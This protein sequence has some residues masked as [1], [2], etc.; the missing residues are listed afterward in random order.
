MC[1]VQLLHEFLLRCYDNAV[2]KSF[3]FT[4][5]PSHGLFL[6]FDQ[7]AWLLLLLSVPGV[8]EFFE[9]GLSFQHQPNLPII[10]IIQSAAEQLTNTVC[11]QCL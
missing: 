1:Y 8:G 9:G 4:V 7:I 10:Y 5:T 11:T 6:D 3:F 2:L